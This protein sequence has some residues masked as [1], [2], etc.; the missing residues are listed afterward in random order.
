MNTYVPVRTC[1]ESILRYSTA[2]EVMLAIIKVDF[3]VSQRHLSPAGVIIRQSPRPTASDHRRFRFG[4]GEPE[5]YGRG[6]NADPPLADSLTTEKT[7]RHWSEYLVEWKQ[8]SIAQP[9]F[10]VLVGLLVEGQ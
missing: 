8:A 10:R 9:L 7:E 1:R 3:D 6:S 4:P 2:L 5:R